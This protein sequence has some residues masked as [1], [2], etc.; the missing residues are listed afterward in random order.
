MPLD[1]VN[2]SVFERLAVLGNRTF[3][4]LGAEGTREVVRQFTDLAP[5][6]PAMAAVEDVAAPVRMRLYRPVDRDDLPVTL[7]VHG[8]GF[9]FGGI[10]EYDAFCRHLARASETVVVSVGYRLAPEHPFPA[11]LDDAWAALRWAAR[12]PG[13]DRL[14]V[15]GDSAGGNLAAAL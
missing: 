3:A 7:W 5:P 15:A 4:S 9:V 11:G 10:G 2:Q 8:G 12:L 13:G 6:G 14:A 1:P